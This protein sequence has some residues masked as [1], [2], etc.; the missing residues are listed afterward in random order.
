MIQSPEGQDTAAKSQKQKSFSSKWSGVTAT[1]AL[2]SGNEVSA[3]DSQ[4]RGCFS[5]KERITGVTSAKRIQLLSQERQK[6]K[7][8]ALFV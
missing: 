7:E 8:T 1:G 4:T 2:I 3:T 6:S 5:V